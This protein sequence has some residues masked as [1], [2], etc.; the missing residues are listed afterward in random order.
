MF[1]INILPNVLVLVGIGNMPST[2]TLT[3]QEQN[4]Q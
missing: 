4:Q 1:F 3:D 2:I